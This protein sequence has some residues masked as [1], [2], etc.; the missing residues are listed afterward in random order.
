MFEFSGFI[1]GVIKPT[2]EGDAAWLLPLSLKK[3]LY[4]QS[5]NSNN[6]NTNEEKNNYYRPA[7]C[8]LSRIKENNCLLLVQIYV[9][10]VVIISILRQFRLEPKITDKFC[11]CWFL[12]SSRRRCR[13]RRSRLNIT[14]KTI[15]LTG[16]INEFHLRNIPGKH[17]ISSLSDAFSLRWR[18]DYYDFDWADNH[19]HHDDARDESE[20]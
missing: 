1:K 11:V 20:L 9:M 3:Y 16:C 19:H 14:H 13:C 18:L 10:V 8:C 4:R 5:N 12:L 2:F 17:L 15:L 7:K 6:N